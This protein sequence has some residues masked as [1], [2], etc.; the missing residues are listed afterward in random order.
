[1]TQF[2]TQEN[3][4]NITQR[5]AG[6]MK[7][8][9]V[10]A[11]VNQK[12][13][14]GKSTIAGTLTTGLQLRGYKTLLIELDPQSNAAFCFRADI[15][16]PSE[17]NILDSILQGQPLADLIQHTEQGDIIPAVATLAR[18]DIDLYK[19]FGDSP[20]QMTAL[21]TAIEPLQ[22]LY[23]YILI[24][25]APALNR[26]SYNALV[27]ANE[28]VVPAKPE[29]YS[30]QAIGQLRQTIESV[31][32][33][34]NKDLHVAGVLLTMYEGK[35]SLHKDI[36]QTLKAFETQ[37]QTKVIQHPIRKSID[38]AA[39]QNER[40]D[41]FSYRRSNGSKAPVTADYNAVIN[42]LLEREG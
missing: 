16:D 28:A 19:Q 40:T 17:N 15:P 34:Y 21:K 5:K 2:I 26:M 20:E 27:A 1:M 4:Y 9:T 11:I 23:D 13:G 25:T 38:V 29:V 10:I 32:Q 37:L 33:N 22:Q 6:V 3:T 36:V 42:D 18:A 24:D 12:G 30:L 35:T 14:I 8:G 39:A 31:K 7:K 41:I